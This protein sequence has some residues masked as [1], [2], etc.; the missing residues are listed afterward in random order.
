MLPAHILRGSV[1]SR[2][3]FGAASLKSRHYL[4][5]LPRT[6]SFWNPSKTPQ[7]I[8]YFAQGV[9]FMPTL[10]L[11]VRSTQLRPLTGK[12]CICRGSTALLNVD[13]VMFTSLASDPHEL[14]H[15]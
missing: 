7:R 2:P 6:A 4:S 14:P 9:T 5:T 15:R 11:T 12:S 3:V 10:P 13:R 8:S 1:T